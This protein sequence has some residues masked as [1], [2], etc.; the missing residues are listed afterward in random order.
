MLYKGPIPAGLYVCHTCDDPLCVNPEHLFLGSMQDNMQDAWRKGRFSH[1]G[2]ILTTEKIAFAK[3]LHAEKALLREIS[4]A[5][6]IPRG[7]LCSVL[8]CGKGPTL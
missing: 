5:T 6:G 8:Y 2:T 4:K 7:T 3:K 1:R